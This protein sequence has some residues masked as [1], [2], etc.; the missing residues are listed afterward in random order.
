MGR[1]C[2]YCSENRKLTREHVW[3]NG[4]I[5]R[6]NYEARYSEQAGKFFGADQVISDVCEECNNGVLSNLDT[7]ICSMFDH[8]FANFIQK[9]EF[10][11]FHYNYDLLARW[12]LKIS[13]N[14]SRSTGEDVN[15]LK[16]YVPYIMGKSECPDDTFSIRIELVSPSVNNIDKNMKKL[17]PMSARCCRIKFQGIQLNWCTIRLVSINSYY[18]WLI[19]TPEETKNQIVDDRELQLVA[20]NLPRLILEQDHTDITLTASNRNTLIMHQDWVANQRDKFEEYLHR[21]G[22]K[23]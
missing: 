7:Y 11:N 12:L 15:L 10:V 13:Y 8:Y 23:K 20:K 5:Q 21:G 1:I 17:F 6:V 2:A 18:F 9:G 3:P 14:S 16:N 22:R 4:I 19:F